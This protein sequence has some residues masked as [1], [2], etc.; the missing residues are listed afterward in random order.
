[1]KTRILAVA[2]L[3]IFAL[4]AH[5]A[6]PPTAESL[7]RL[8]A[9]IDS[10]EVQGKLGTAQ[11]VSSIQE[12]GNGAYTVITNEC[13]LEVRVEPIRTNPPQMVPELRVIVGQANCLP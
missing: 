12:N 3:G 13:A 7:R 1:M 11:W 5:A 8:R 4:N 2:A 6:L 9:V 10:A